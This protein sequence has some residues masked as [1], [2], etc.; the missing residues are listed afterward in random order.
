MP[1][2]ICRLNQA[3]PLLNIA[4]DKC[5]ANATLCGDEGKCINDESD[6]AC[7]RKRKTVL[8]SIQ[9]QC[10]QNQIEKEREKQRDLK[11]HRDLQNKVL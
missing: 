5:G 10:K 7:K 4:E 6:D 11:T 9:D 8:Q 3:I 1:L 2:P